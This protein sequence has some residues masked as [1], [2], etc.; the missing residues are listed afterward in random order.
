[1][2]YKNV[3][4]LNLPQLPLQMLTVLTHLDR[5]KCYFSLLS[6]FKRT[7]GAKTCKLQENRIETV[8]KASSNLVMLV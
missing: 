8:F 5:T 3:S 4:I 6:F 7:S 2:Y 1:M